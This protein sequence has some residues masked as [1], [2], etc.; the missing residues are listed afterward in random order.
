MPRNGSRDSNPENFIEILRELT[1]NGTDLTSLYSKPDIADRFVNL[2]DNMGESFKRNK[3]ST[4][5]IRKVLENIKKIYE[6]YKKNKSEQ[7][8]AKVK[9]QLLPLAYNA[10]RFRELKP[11]YTVLSWFIKQIKKPED[12]EALKYFIDGI[13]A[14]HR[15]HGGK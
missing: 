9:L 14:Y 5:Q 15:Y 3:I 12:I 11:F 4:S 1:N 7:L 2:V 13:V 8:V 6:E 10:G